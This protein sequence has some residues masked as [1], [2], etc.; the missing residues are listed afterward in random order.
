MFTFS[1]PVPCPGIALS[2]LG[3]TEP[4]GEWGKEQCLMVQE[5]QLLC[6]FSEGDTAW[7]LYDTYGFPVDLTGLIAEE[8]GL[9]VDMEGFEEERKNAQVAGWVLALPLLGSGLLCLH[10]GWC[11]NSLL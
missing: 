4:V 6:S 11:W 9:V 7:L 10:A 3:G 8:K 5:C 1:R 2:Q